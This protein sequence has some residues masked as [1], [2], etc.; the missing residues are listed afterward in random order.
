MNQTYLWSFNYMQLW[1]NLLHA[2]FGYW[3]VTQGQ[4]TQVSFYILGL[5]EDIQS[6]MWLN[7][8]VFIQDLNLKLVELTHTSNFSMR[9]CFFYFVAWSTCVVKRVMCICV[10][11]I[12][13][14]WFR[15]WPFAHSAPRNYLNQWWL[16]CNYISVEFELKI[17]KNSFQKAKWMK[18]SSKW[19]LIYLHLNMLSVN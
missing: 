13:H 12:S 4:Y 16:N 2:Y 6:M 1:P 18:M 9:Y 17:K 3:Y 19:C 11:W 10:S 14:H 7:P 5:L 8:T 15:W